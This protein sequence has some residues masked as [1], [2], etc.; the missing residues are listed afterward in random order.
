MDHLTFQHTFTVTLPKHS[1]AVR[2]T[3]NYAPVQKEARHLTLLLNA[4]GATHVARRTSL[5]EHNKQLAR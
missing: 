1:I 5:T 3:I 2:Q 4:H